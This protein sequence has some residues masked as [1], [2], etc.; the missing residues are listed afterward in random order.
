MTI[1]RTEMKEELFKIKEK[2]SKKKVFMQSA[3]KLR[4]KPL[5]LLLLVTTCH[6]IHADLDIT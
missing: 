1:K 5:P 4:I 6:I 3:L 2:G